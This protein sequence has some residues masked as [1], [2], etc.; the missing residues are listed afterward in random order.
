MQLSS[1]IAFVID[2]LPGIG[3]AEKVLMAALELFPGA[4]VYTLL[5]NREKFV[6]TPIA[7]HQ[8]NTSFIQ[9][10]PFARMQYR[11]YLPVMPLAM[12]QFN[13]SAYDTVISFS[14]AVAHGVRVHAGQNLLSYTFTPMRYAWSNIGLDGKPRRSS[15]VLDRI[16]RQFREWDLTA[17]NR[18]H[19]L[20]AV[21][22]WISAWIRRAYRRDSCV[23]YPPVEIERFTPASERDDYFVTISRLVPHK[24]VDLLVD[25][26]NCLG[27]PLFIIGDGPERRNLEERA[28]ENVRFLGFQPDSVIDGLLNRARAYVCPGS[29]DFGIAMVE[30]QA[31]GCPLIA[32]GYGGALEI[33]LEDQ[34]GIFF[35]ESTPESLIAAV[36]RFD[37]SSISV[38]DCALNAR[39]FDKKR[40]HLELGAFIDNSLIN[41]ECTANRLIHH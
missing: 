29:E 20:A 24:R 25:A 11:K 27:L 18:V 14:Y 28:R 12:R 1:K 22:G 10:L 23:I 7:C 9:R 15:L 26:F 39:R 37:K 3:G 32:F 4:P 34:T 41:S 5:Y 40:F 19:R 16:F 21:S 6:H 30:A 8:V 13:L 31:A 38:Y 33:V 17:V 2:A 36:E 35:N